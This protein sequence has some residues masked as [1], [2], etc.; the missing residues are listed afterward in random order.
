MAAKSQVKITTNVNFPRSAD[1]D[2]EPGKTKVARFGRFAIGQTLTVGED[3]SKERADWLVSK[4][5][6]VKVTAKGE[7]VD[8]EGKPVG[9]KSDEA[10]KQATREA[11]AQHEKPA[12]Q[13]TAQEGETEDAAASG[14]RGKRSS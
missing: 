1:L 6:A 11:S 10:V 9:P 5:Y 2:G 7:E 12:D 4:K 13:G 14:R 8:D 3:I